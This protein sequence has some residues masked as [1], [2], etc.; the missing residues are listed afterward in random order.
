MAVWDTQMEGR[1]QLLL[2]VEVRGDMLDLDS[3]NKSQDVTS[4]GL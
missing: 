2:V 4:K 1:I 3:D